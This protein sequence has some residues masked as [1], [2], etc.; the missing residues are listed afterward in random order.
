MEL[1]SRALPS[2]LQPNSFPMNCVS[3][4]KLQRSAELSFHLEEEKAVKLK[5]LEWEPWGMREG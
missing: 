2:K 4:Q 5:G 3:S 1:T